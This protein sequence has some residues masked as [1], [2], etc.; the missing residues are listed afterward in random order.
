MKKIKLYFK[1]VYRN[2]LY[3]YYVKKAVNLWIITSKKHFVLMKKNTSNPKG[4]QFT[5]KLKIICTDAIY[6]SQQQALVYHTPNGKKK[7]GMSKNTI[8]MYRQRYL[9]Y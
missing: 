5:P 4:K 7:F 8:E 2:I 1:C 3:Q 6:K 9:N